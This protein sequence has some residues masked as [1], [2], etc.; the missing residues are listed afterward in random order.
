VFLLYKL[1][2][3][4]SKN[5]SNLKDNYMLNTQNGIVSIN[6]INQ[7]IYLFK[8]VLLT[9][10]SNELLTSD[11][12]SRILNIMKLLY[13]INITK[14]FFELKKKVDNISELISILSKISAEGI[15]TTS[16]ILKKEKQ[17]NKLNESELKLIKEK[18]EFFNSI[19]I[20]LEQFCL[21][22]AL[23]ESETIQKK[24]FSQI[25]FFVSRSIP[26]TL[27]QKVINLLQDWHQYFSQLKIKYQNFW[28]DVINMFYCLFMNNPSIQNNTSDIEKL[29]TLL[30]KKYMITF[31]DENKMSE[32][33][34]NEKREEI[35]IVKKIYIMVEG[36][37]HKITNS[38][39]LNWFESTKNMIK[40]YFPEVLVDKK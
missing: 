14:I 25:S 10:K 26:Q 34:S 4:L 27:I 15:D 2:L 29:W 11:C 7:V 6:Q 22:S 23:I 20:F 24:F 35:E 12:C 37:V 18:N 21:K 19:F 33:S 30:I 40:L 9:I 36:I 5:I 16:N 28:K 13:D 31:N 38:Q 8:N 39:K 1:F 3:Q 32:N 17:N